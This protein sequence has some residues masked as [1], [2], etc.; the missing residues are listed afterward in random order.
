MRELGLVRF[1]VPSDVRS[2]FF[3]TDIADEY[4]MPTIG[5]DI[6]VIAGIAKATISL[7]AHDPTYLEEACEGWES[8]LDWIDGLAWSELG[9]CG[10]ESDLER[11]AGLYAESRRTIFAWTMGITHHEHGVANVQSIGG[12]AMLRGMLGRPGAGLLPLRG[13]S[14]VQGVGSVGVTPVLKPPILAGLERLLSTTMPSTPGLDTMAC[15]ERPIAGTSTSRSA[16]AAISSVR[17]GLRLRKS[18]A[19][20]RASGGPALDDHQH[21]SLLRTGRETLVLPVLAR[22]EE[23]QSTTQESMFN[24]VRVSDGGSA[25]HDGPR[26]E[27][28]LVCELGERVVS[29]HPLDWNAM[30][31]H[32]EVRSLISGSSRDTARFPRSARP[33]GSSPS[34]VASSTS[35]ASRPRAGRHVSTYSNCRP[36]I[37]TGRAPR[38]DGAERRPFNTVVYEEDLY[39]GQERRDVILM[40]P[41]DMA[42]RGLAADDPVEV[43]TGRFTSRPCSSVRDRPRLRGDVLPRGEHH[44][45]PYA[46]R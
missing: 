38:H 24:Y 41:D 2:L 35:R 32:D 40:H 31:D 11:V 25:R 28:D 34:M 20:E 42:D 39:R 29:H 19:S 30:R 1:K 22:D 23:S 17:I 12:L 46:R 15:M 16:S 27:V 44:R 7:G 10:L 14:N 43:T 9:G 8:W 5:S 13:H 33:G 36:S 37:S 6:A 45:P 3:G 4:L 26:G 21:R 18:R